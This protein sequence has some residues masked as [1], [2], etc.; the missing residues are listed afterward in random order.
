MSNGA[1]RRLRLPAARMRAAARSVPFLR[2]KGRL[3]HPQLS[4]AADS[5]T[6]CRTIGAARISSPFTGVAVPAVESCD[7]THH[8]GRE[9]PGLVPRHTDNQETQ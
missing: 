6:M 5:P 1:Q 7:R 4:R 9:R 3:K 2:R 8:A